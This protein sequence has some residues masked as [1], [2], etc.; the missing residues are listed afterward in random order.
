MGVAKPDDQFQ[1]SFRNHGL[2]RVLGRPLRSHVLFWK[3]CC[4]ECVFNSSCISWDSGGLVRDGWLHRFQIRFS[5]SHLWR[6]QRHLVFRLQRRSTQTRPLCP[7]L[8][9]SL[10]NSSSP[11]VLP[12]LLLVSAWSTDSVIKDWPAC[13]CDSSFEAPDVLIVVATEEQLSSAADS[14]PERTQT[15]V[16][17]C[18]FPQCWKLHRPSIVFMERLW[19]I[20]RLRVYG[21]LWNACEHTPLSTAV[22]NTSSLCIYIQHC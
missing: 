19:V 11:Q 5:S 3:D 22:E 20:T 21:G 6:D 10:I 14:R 17:S 7:P 15:R 8:S 2:K 12:V 4:W 1:K 18:Y 16:R 9:S 13:L